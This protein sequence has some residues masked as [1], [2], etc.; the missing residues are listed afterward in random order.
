[1]GL[2]DDAIAE[3]KLVMRDPTREV[4]CHLMIGLCSLEKGQVTDA[5]GQFKKGLYVEGITD[6]E[7][8]SL[9]FEL[10][11]AYERLGDA[12]EALYYYEK[13]LKR[14]PRFRNVE[15]LVDQLRSGSN[16]APVPEPAPAPTSRDDVDDAFDTLLGSSE[17]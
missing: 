13:V 10:G 7:S 1:M 3:F 14:D 17:S 12:R 4:Q 2:V 5:I 15:K 16:A 9:Y 8:F 11:Q 6:R